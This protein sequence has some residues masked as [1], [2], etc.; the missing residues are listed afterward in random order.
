MI[1]L[2]R[3]MVLLFAALSCASATAFA[4]RDAACGERVPLAALIANPDAYH[5][6]AL[7]VVAHAT[8]DFENMTACPSANDTEIR[9]CL[10]LDID[11]GP[12]KTDQDYARY[13][14]KR[15]RWDRFNRETVAIRAT[16]DR[17]LKGHMSLWPGGL[18]RVAE[19]SGSQVGW[20]FIS[21]SAVPRTACAGE[22]P[23]AGR[24]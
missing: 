16:F 7:W 21:S 15:H 10:W 24:R 20:N 1:A 11:D 14:A 6:K 2:N 8:I 3:S 9:N 5:G 12:Y 19:V 18:R 22:L 4:A 17:T 13:L 23:Q